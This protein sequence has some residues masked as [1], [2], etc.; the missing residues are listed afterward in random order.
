[1][2]ARDR[3]FGPRAALSRSS[4][5]ADHRE[6]LVHM[7]A[8]RHRPV[9]LLAVGALIAGAI[10]LTASGQAATG[11]KTSGTLKLVVQFDRDADARDDLAPA[12][13]SPGDQVMESDPVFASDNRTRRGR[14]MTLTT[15]Q[16]G[17]GALVAG[18]LRL[19][20]GTITLAGARVNGSGSLAVT[21]G[22]GAYAG[23]RGTYTETAAPFQVIGEDGPTRH[24]VTIRFTD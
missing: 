4:L 22:T 14:A 19:S 8:T 3:S 5:F 20:D 15:F 10:A 17:Q 18:A 24:R 7:I 9:L 16:S 6:E 12:G 23:A 2:V 11:S 21:G 13:D 1:V